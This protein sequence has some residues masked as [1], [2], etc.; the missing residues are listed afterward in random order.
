MKKIPKMFRSQQMVWRKCQRFGE[1]GMET[2]ETSDK[3]TL[4]PLHV[5]WP[6]PAPYYFTLYFTGQGRASGRE[7][8]R[9]YTKI[10]QTDGG[11][12]VCCLIIFKINCKQTYIQRWKSWAKW[13]HKYGHYTCSHHKNELR[14]TPFLH[15]KIL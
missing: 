11:N 8:W 13:L 6:K 12:Q 7:R 4:F 3:L 5:D 10:C 9:Y 15:Q 2:M 14:S 1:S